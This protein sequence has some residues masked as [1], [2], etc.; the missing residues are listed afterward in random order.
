MYHEPGGSSVE[1]SWRHT[2]GE[3]WQVGIDRDDHQ[4]PTVAGRIA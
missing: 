4:L 3:P 2:L 1:S